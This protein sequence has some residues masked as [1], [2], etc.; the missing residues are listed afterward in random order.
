MMLTQTHIHNISPTEERESESRSSQIF[1]DFF[2]VKLKR[3][4]VYTWCHFVKHVRQPG[5]RSQR[6]LGTSGVP[7]LIYQAA[8]VIPWSPSSMLLSSSSL[9]Y[10]RLHFLTSLA[11]APVPGLS[12]SLSGCLLLEVSENLNRFEPKRVQLEVLIRAHTKRA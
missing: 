1:F 8:L 6:Q 12:F 11:P 3:R 4:R 10:R 5:I 9:V 7:R 2:G